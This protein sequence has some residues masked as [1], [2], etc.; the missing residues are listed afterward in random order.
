MYAIS[1]AFVTRSD[2]GRTVPNYSL[3]F[4]RL[5]A[6]AIANLYHPASDRGVGLTFENAFLN[7]G[8]HAADNLVREFLVR[9]FIRSVPSFENGQGSAPQK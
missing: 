7:I 4:G 6:G 1:R 2:K 9:K 3:L 5:T 8:G